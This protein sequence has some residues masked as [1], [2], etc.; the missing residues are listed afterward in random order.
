MAKSAERKAE[1]EKR[2]AALA[3][4]L[5]A[6]EVGMEFCSAATIAVN[7]Y[8]YNS[9]MKSY[10]SKAQDYLR[11]AQREIIVAHYDTNKES[12]RG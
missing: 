4:A 9:D 5:N 1:L 6:A 10:L 12:S 11:A 7:D 8:P 2:M 3:T